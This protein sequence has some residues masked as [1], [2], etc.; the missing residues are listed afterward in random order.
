MPFV[1]AANEQMVTFQAATKNTR[2]TFRTYLEQPPYSLCNVGYGWDVP[3]EWAGW[4]PWPA[5]D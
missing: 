4:P 5:V 3:N 1:L 2:D